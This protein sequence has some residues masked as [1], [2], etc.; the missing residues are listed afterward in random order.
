MLPT[1]LH[2]NFKY[3]NTE[4][5]LPTMCP[6]G[7]LGD[8]AVILKVKFFKFTTQN[9]SLGKHTVKLLSVALFTYMD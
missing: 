4:C 5:N 1:V 8:M 3:N 2:C 9:N 7:P 6:H